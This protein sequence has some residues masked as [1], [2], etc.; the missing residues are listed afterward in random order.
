MRTTGKLT[1]SRTFELW[2]DDHSG[3]LVRKV[4]SVVRDTTTDPTDV[5]RMVVESRDAN[6]VGNTVHL[7]ACWN[8]IES[9]GGSPAIVGELVTAL[10][11]FVSAELDEVADRLT[12]PD[13]CGAGIIYDHGDYLR[14]HSPCPTCRPLARQAR[15]LLARVKGGAA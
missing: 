1:I 15:A 4:A 14:E 2:P 3:S 8:A 12:C 7:A 9:A 11:E 10:E 5:E 6:A 13:C